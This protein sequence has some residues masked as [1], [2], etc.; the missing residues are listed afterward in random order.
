M[1]TAR[2][3]G[4]TGADATVAV[5]SEGTGLGEIAVMPLDAAGARPV[6]I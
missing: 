5:L 6:R 1:I 2:L 3:S 4:G